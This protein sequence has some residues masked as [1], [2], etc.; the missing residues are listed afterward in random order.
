M[1]FKT[2]W[3]AAMFLDLSEEIQADEHELKNRNDKIG[4]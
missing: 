4:K 3:L 2:L 1:F